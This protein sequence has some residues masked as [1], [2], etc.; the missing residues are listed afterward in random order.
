MTFFFEFKLT[1]YNNSN[2]LINV[3]SK[4]EQLK[5]VKILS[6]IRMSHLTHKTHYKMSRHQTKSLK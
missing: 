4:V 6:I 2:K 1:S 5:S 3:K